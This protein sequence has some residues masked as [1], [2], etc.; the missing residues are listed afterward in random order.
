MMHIDPNLPVCRVKR[1]FTCPGWKEWGGVGWELPYKSDRKVPKF[2]LVGVALVGTIPCF[3]TPKSYNE[4][5][6]TLNGSCAPSH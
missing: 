2:H 3:S 5:P 1:M 6:F 4:H